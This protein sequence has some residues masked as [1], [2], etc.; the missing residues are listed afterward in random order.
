MRE[1]E[2]EKGQVGQ[3]GIFK[4]RE[5]T[6][7]SR[8]GYLSISLIVLPPLFSSQI[9][10]LKLKLMFCSPCLLGLVMW[11][12]HS[13]LTSLTKMGRDLVLLSLER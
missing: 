2:G 11:V 1:S 4:R 8:N 7:L 12:K 3:L 5:K 6:L 10:L 9:F 13:F